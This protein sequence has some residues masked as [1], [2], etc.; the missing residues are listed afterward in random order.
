[1]ARCRLDDDGRRLRQPVLGGCQGVGSRKWPWKDR[2]PG[3]DPDES[4]DDAPGEADG[5]AE[6]RAL[7]DVRGAAVPSG[8][9]RGAN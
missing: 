1:M 4:K 3:T 2:R 8:R 5:R 7:E 9:A 6:I